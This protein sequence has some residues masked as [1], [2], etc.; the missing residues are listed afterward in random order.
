MENKSHALALSTILIIMLSVT[1]V[2]AVADEPTPKTR[3]QENWCIADDGDSIDY[4]EAVS[5]GTNSY[6]DANETSTFLD[7]K[8]YIK[9]GV[10][11]KA[12]LRVIHSEDDGTPMSIAG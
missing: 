10:Q 11:V 9:D 4:L 8:N 12:I 7:I 3:L 1:L 6:D 5:L 2:T